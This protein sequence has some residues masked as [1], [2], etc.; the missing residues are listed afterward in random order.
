MINVEATSSESVVNA[1]PIKQS[2]AR[3][4]AAPAAAARKPSRWSTIFPSAM[5]RDQC[6]DTGM[7]M[8][9]VLLLLFVWR[10]NPSYV[11]GAIAAHLVN[12]TAPQLFRPA[13]IVWFG[14]SHIMGTIVSRVLLTAI[15]FVVVT[16][17]AVVRQMI[18]ADPMQLRGFKKSKQSVMKVRN[19]K[20]T[21]KDIEQP[22]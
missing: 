9:L 3:S 21:A 2:P 1:M 16:P 4:P 6:K 17:V 20:F 14:L 11:A 15:F 19:H 13:A 18:G 12:M 8:V 22:Y 5:T 7:A 10:G